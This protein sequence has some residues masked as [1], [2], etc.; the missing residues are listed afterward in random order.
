MG[1][2]NVWRNKR[3][4]AVT[5][6]AMTLALWVLLLY[7]GF[8]PGYLQN[9]EEGVTELEVG[10]IQIHADGYLTSPSLYTVIEDSAEIVA[11]LEEAGIAAS[12][13][14][15]GGGLGASGEFSAGVALRGLDVERDARVSKLSMTVG[16]GEWLDPADPEGVVLGKSLAKTLN[17]EVGGEL[18]V[19]SQAADGSMA[20]D[21]FTVKGI[22]KSVAQGTDRTAVLMN[23]SAFRE[24]MVVPTGDHQIVLRRGD[25]ELSAVAEQVKALAPG[26]DVRTWMELMPAVAQ[27]LQSVSGMIFVFYLIAY[28][29]VG[30]LILNAMLT[31]VFERI[32]E[33]GVLKA[34][35]AGP[36]RVLSVI[37][38]EGAAQAAVATVLGVTLAIPGMWFMQNHGINAGALGGMDAAGVAMPEIWYGIYT[39]EACSGPI[40]LLWVITMAA[41]LYPAL[42]AAWINPISAMRYR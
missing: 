5:I 9:M 27:M 13:R 21:L 33:F 8:I 42:K 4:S 24:L 11:R 28:I 22:L 16:E 6:A 17:V 29:A 20:N 19:V 38:V 41:V 12:P 26:A 14:L 1:W 10:D 30:I 37:L 15:A 32:R 34:I 2:R 40:I 3:R 7:A 25:G 39:A 35:G 31:A 23:A 18:L 36:V